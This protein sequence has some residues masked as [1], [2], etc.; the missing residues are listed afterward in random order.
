MDKM[1]K[2]EPMQTALQM[3]DT[4]S[5]LLV[6]QTKPRLPHRPRRVEVCLVALFLLLMVFAFNPVA[7][8]SCLIADYALCAE[9]FDFA[10]SLR[11]RAERSSIS[12]GFSGFVAN[13]QNNQQQL[14]HQ[15]AKSV[16]TVEPP[17]AELP[18]QQARPDAFQERILKG[19]FYMD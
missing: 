8:S 12:G 15:R 13:Q 6:L 16:A 2:M 17:K 4:P 10:E 19:D 7:L 1:D 9:G 18:K 5:P 14:P 3:V 11:A